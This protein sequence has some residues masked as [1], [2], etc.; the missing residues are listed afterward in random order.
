LP[1]PL[2]GM[3]SQSPARRLYRPHAMLLVAQTGYFTSDPMASTTAAVP[4][5]TI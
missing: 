2:R 5:V 3:P 1:P 4:R